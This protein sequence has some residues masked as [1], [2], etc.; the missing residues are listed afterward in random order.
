MALIRTFSLW[1]CASVVWSAIAW[2]RD[3]PRTV[4]FEPN[5]GQADRSTAFL[6]RGNEYTTLLRWDGAALY[7]LSSRAGG[8]EVRMELRG[9]AASVQAS[10]EEPLPSVTRIYRGGACAV[11]RIEVPQYQI[12]RAPD[13]YPGIDM[14]WRFRGPKLEYEFQV[15]PGANPG[16][17]ELHFSGADG[18]FISRAGDLVAETPAGALHHRRPVAWQEIAGKREAVEVRFRLN[19]DI[20][21]FQLGHYDPS[22][23][24]WIDPILT[25]ASYVGGAGYDAAYAV[26]LDS[27]GGIYIT[28]ATSS[29]SFSTQSS[30]LR[31]SQDAFV[32]KFNPNGSL[33]YTTILASSADD[34]GQAIAVDPAGNVYVA[35]TTNGSDFPATAGAWRTTSGGEQDGFAAK[36]DPFGNLVYAS[37]IGGPGND[38]ATG[39]AIDASGSAYVSGYTA[40]AP[41]FPATAGAPQ[42]VYGGGADDA[43]LVKLN[44]TGSTALYA[45]LLGGSGADL[46]LAVAL[47]PGGSA[48]VAGYTN[49]SDLHV[50]AALQS[51]PGGE[52]DALLAC[53]NPAGTAWTTVSY[54]GGSGRDEAYALAIDGAGNI[55]LAGTTF[56]AD[57]PASASALQPALAGRYDAFLAKFSPGGYGQVFATL[58]GGTG[59]DAATTLAVGSGQDVWIAGYTT[60]LDFPVV[61]AWQSSNHG[62]SDSFV[63]HVSADGTAL[64]AS[65]YLGG[66]QDDQIWGMALSAGG[67]VTVA[68]ATGS[69]DIPV[70]A[71]AFQP[72]APGGYNAFLAQIDPHWTGYAISG[73]VTVSGT[74]PLAGISVQL[75]GSATGSATTDASGNFAFTGLLAGGT[76]IIT[77]SAGGYRFSPP[78]QT[79]GNL[80]ADQS[81]GFVASCQLGVNP[82]AVY[83]DS[84]GQFAPPLTVTTSAPSCLWVA[85]ANASFIDITSGTNGTGT[86]SITFS[87]PPNTTGAGLSGTVTVDNQTVS[88]VQRATTGSFADVNPP[89]Y[90]FD[91]VNA[92][93]AAKITGGCS[94]VP[95]DYCPASPTTRGQMA[96]FIVMAIEGGSNFSYAT[97]P[98]FT[99]VP[100]G[101]PFFKFIQKMADLG[102]TSGCGNHL[103]CPDSPVTRGQMAV[104][105]I[106]ARY[107][108]IPFT[109][110]A[111]AYF[112][113]MPPSNPFFPFVQKMAQAG[114]TGGCA[115]GLFCPNTV[116]NRGQM[117]VFIV[118]GLLNELLAPNVPAI[119]HA[120]PNG[121]T[122]GQGVTVTL[123]GVNTHFVQ[124]VT[125]VTAA[126]GILVSGIS[127]ASATSLS[128]SLAVPSN[129]SPGPSTLVVTTGTEE[130][131]LPNG[132]L[133]Q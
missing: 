75:S 50:L 20:A 85:S 92:L 4:Y 56:S 98:Y 96:V 99:D 131:A 132:F 43:F 72:A 3:T 58:F 14:L 15:N 42:T 32:A 7:H 13:V 115:P 60:S 100:P 87:V 5:L 26:A 90:Y 71:K 47:G 79:F 37:Y 23:P 46:A 93:Y 103:Y 55:Y 113:D 129:L 111:A 63:A 133:V 128:V 95:A 34:S 91:F 125:Q 130:A 25:Y 28:G 120:A 27:A 51:T 117:A 44:A 68:G 114:I 54:Y 112:S 1:Y 97:A 70:T 61:G 48:C 57:F 74:A 35:G 21:G 30:A 107:G 83:L 38:V 64:L 36:L 84:R 52:G 39:I 106:Q 8:S 78:S 101:N 12:V 2:G 126:P 77:P 102:I 118:S 127:V 45:T 104:F 9:G 119:T 76:Y 116:L 108:K 81:A 6:A 67:L 65:S 121:A 66:S 17:I 22:L 18:L 11:S 19:G 10:G 80:S 59:S 29:A 49:S 86:G 109:H 88:V 105:I 123:T 31:T 122:R 82:A 124:G 40:S 73:Q 110:P 41:G 33:A 94:A 16:R 62:S 69:T 89:D 53:I 24:L